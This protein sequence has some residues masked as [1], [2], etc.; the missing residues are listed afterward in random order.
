[1]R[2]HWTFLDKKVFWLT[3]TLNNLEN[4]RFSK[5]A[6]GGR[7]IRAQDLLAFT[8]E[9]TNSSFLV[10][11][12]VSL[13]S[14]RGLSQSLFSMKAVNQ[15]LLTYDSAKFDFYKHFNNAKCTAFQKPRKPQPLHHFR[16]KLFSP[17]KTQKLK[18]N[19]FSPRR[20][21]GTRTQITT[22]G[23]KLTTTASLER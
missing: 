5:W 12:W 4:S 20:L 16:I 6:F 15:I 10:C 14:C 18:T 3:L 21:L 8:Q 13:E 1:M 22:V 17:K 7:G 11:L 23:P 9:P 2:L 19:L